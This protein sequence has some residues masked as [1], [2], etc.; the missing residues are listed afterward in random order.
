MRALRVAVMLAM[1]AIAGIGP[2]R[3]QMSNMPAHGGV[4]AG[5]T[6]STTAYKAAMGTMMHDM[7]I[8]YTGNADRDF[9]AGMLPHHQGAV[10]M[11]KVE[12]RYGHDPDLRKLAEGIVAAQEKEIAFMRA[13]QAKHR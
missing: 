1:A 9:V 10:D 13:W 7:D 11:A 8:T 2:V 12:L 3:A 5:D 4:S 6:A